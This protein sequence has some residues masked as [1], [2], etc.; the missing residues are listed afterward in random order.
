[1]EEFVKIDEQ[2]GSFY[3]S[4]TQVTRKEFER[5]MG[6]SFGDKKKVFSNE[7]AELRPVNCVSFYNCLVYCNLRSLQDGLEPCYSI[8]G[9][10]NPAQWGKVSKYKIEEK[11]RN[12]VCNF[13]CSGYRLPTRAEWETAAKGSGDYKYSGSDDLNEV[14][15]FLNNS[16]G[17][18][19]QVALKKPNDYGLF[20]MSGNVNEWGWDKKFEDRRITFGGGFFQEDFC[21][22]IL[23]PGWYA[24]S[25]V[26]D[27]LG[28]RT[29]RTNLSLFN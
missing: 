15:W 11:W 2:E 12:V 20:D 14:G 8:D 21:C 5:V 25:S 9:T 1:M 22:E 17:R 28:F 18:S 19:H 13:E 23:N 7:E 16:F 6:V 27:F 26:Y 3:I 29:V 4:K 10:S 24:E